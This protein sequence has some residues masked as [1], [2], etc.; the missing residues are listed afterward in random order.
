MVSTTIWPFLKT[1]ARILEIRFSLV[2][3]RQIAALHRAG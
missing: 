1:A 3:A 2:S